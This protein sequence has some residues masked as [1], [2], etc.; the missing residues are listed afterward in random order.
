MESSPP[1]SPATVEKEEAS[2]E[3]EDQSPPANLEEEEPETSQILTSP[4]ERCEL[5]NWRPISLLNV[6]Y[7]ILS[8]TMVNRVK[9][10]MGEI[11]HLDQTCGVAGRRVADSLALIRDTIQYI[12]DRNIHAALV[13]LD[14]E[15]AFDCV[16]Q[17]FMERVLQGFGSGEWFC[18]YVRIMYT[19]IFSSVM[20]NG[21]RRDPF[22]IR[23]VVRQGCPHSP[24]VF[25]LVIEL[26]AE[27]ISKNPSISGIP[28]PADAKKEVKCTL[29]MDDVT[30]FCA[31]GKS[32]QS[33]LE[34]CKD[35]GKASWSKINVDKSQAKLFG[36]WDLCNKPLPFPIEAGLVKIL[37]IWF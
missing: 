4:G 28:T 30:L 25:V 37:G 36:C 12:T 11:V 13:C 33:L 21:W 19:D 8:K 23:S 14:Q 29:Y 6:D 7:K 15:K 5:K 31:D 34:G 1:P 16:S 17:E 20:V 10:A 3:E 27:Y 2:M 22:P 24:S 9:D 35:F 32:V 18:H 26:L